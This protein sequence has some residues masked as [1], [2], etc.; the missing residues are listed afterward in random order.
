MKKQKKNPRTRRL[1]KRTTLADVAAAAGVSLMTVSNV[2]NGRHSGAVGDETLK[3][4][5]RQIMRLNYRPH[6][7]ARTLRLARGSTIGMIIVH[8]SPLFMASPFVSLMVTGLMNSLNEHGYNLI[9]QGVHPKD[10]NDAAVLRRI[11]SEGIVAHIAGTDQERTNFQKQLSATRVP[12]VILQD[13]RLIRFSD[14]CFINQED[15]FG[16]RQLAEIVVR[17]GARRLVYFKPRPDWPGVLGRERGIQAIVAANRDVSL[18]V[19]TTADQ[20]LTA[21]QRPL[22]AHFERHGIPDAIL[23]SNDHLAIAAMKLVQSMGMVVPQDMAITGFNDF[24]YRTY[25]DPHITTVRSSAYEMGSQAGAQ[26]VN[27]LV[28]GRFANTEIL[29]PVS[30]VLGG[31]TRIPPKI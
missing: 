29:L 22:G 25:A 21:C 12:I 11:N 4:V 7:G 15:E 3:R 16:G 30:L 20:T 8:E 10:F 17:G 31:S 14:C 24:E 5:R 23:A 19:I 2:I 6:E 28:E 1:S 26:M 27:R 9:V 13:H 18:S